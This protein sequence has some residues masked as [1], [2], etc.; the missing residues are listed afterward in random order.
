MYYYYRIYGP[1]FLISKLPQSHPPLIPPR[2]IPPPF[3]LKL[4]IDNYI[5]E[6][7]IS[8]ISLLYITYLDY[9]LLAGPCM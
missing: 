8:W 6:T 5:F 2:A 9:S 1:L 7:L 3:V 4:N